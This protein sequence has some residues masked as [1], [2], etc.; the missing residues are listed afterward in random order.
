MRCLVLSIF[1]FL[2]FACFVTYF[3]RL[4]KIK[5]TFSRDPTREAHYQKASKIQKTY[6][7][8][9]VFHQNKQGGCI[10]NFFSPRKF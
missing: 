6:I 5:F 8:T 1:L 9:S 2:S 7:L 3:F 4:K 10:S